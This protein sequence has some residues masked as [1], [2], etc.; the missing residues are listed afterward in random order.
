M[1]AL[2]DATPPNRLGLAQWLVS[3]EHPLTARVAVNRL[4]Q[5][6]FGAGLVETPED[7]GAQGKQP[8]HPDLLDWLALEFQQ[9]GWDMKRLIRMMVTSAT[10]RQTAISTQESRDIDPQNI[11]LSRSPRY[12]LPAHVIRDQALYLSGLLVEKQGGPS[13][14]PYQPPGLWADFSFGKIKYTQDSGESLYRRSLY[15]FWRR[16]LGPPNMFDEADRKLCSVRMQRTNTPLHALTLLNDITYIEAS[17]VFAESLL[18]Q[19]LNN[20][21]RLNR[22][23]RMMTGRHASQT[24]SEIL[25][26]SLDVAMQ[27]YREH[28]EEASQLLQ[29]GERPPAEGLDAVEVAALASVLNV[30]MNADEVISKE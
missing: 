28:G 26:N 16:S 11:W 10:Y 9:S 25:A 14:K 8:S 2:S 1:P 17:R 13:V 12:R 7:F 21:E 23:F 24:E 5:Q 3:E 18:Q 27:H 30:V 15:T 19:D 4:W 6:F 29:T 20:S 22:A